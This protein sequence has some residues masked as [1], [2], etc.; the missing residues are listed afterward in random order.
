MG[1]CQ[2]GLLTAAAPDKLHKIDNP[3]LFDY[4]FCQ[5]TKMREKAVV[6]EEGCFRIILKDWPIWCCMTK[7]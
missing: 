4:A 7:T 1:P 3:T 5:G 2:N 6:A